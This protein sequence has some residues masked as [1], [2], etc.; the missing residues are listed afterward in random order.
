MSGEEGKGSRLFGVHIYGA[1][2]HCHTR[3]NLRLF[4]HGTHDVGK[5]VISRG[6]SLLVAR[7]TAVLKDS[8]PP[9]QQT[10]VSSK[11]P[12]YL[13]NQAHIYPHEAQYA[14]FLRQGHTDLRPRRT[15]AVKYWS[16]LS[17][18]V[19]TE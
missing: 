16:K 2:V 14:T 15:N 10:P 9:G 3:P 7:R 11:P 13:I 8:Y 18:S 12:K 1:L 5:I 19:S 6:V 4:L 17:V